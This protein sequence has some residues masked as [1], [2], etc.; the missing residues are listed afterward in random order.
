MCSKSSILL[1]CQRP[2]VMWI[3]V[4]ILPRKSSKACILTAPLLYL[5]NAQVA[6]LILVDIV[7]E[8][9]A[10]SALVISTSGNFELR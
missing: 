8:S 2:S 5:P 7:V 9:S 10:K 6:N 3:C 1:S 4:G